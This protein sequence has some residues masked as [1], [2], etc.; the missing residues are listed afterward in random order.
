MSLTSAQQA[1]ALKTLT[2]L[3]KHGTNIHC[4]CSCGYSVDDSKVCHYCGE[5][6]TAMQKQQADKLKIIAPFI[7]GSTQTKKVTLARRFY[8]RFYRANK[9][10]RDEIKIDNIEDDIINM[11][12]KCKKFGA[13][14]LKYFLPDGSTILKRVITDE[15]I[16]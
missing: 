1:A 16:I 7:G 9:N 15:W 2:F 14:E 3:A 6:N 8:N 13:D 11:S 4:Y 12:T 10:G 5:D